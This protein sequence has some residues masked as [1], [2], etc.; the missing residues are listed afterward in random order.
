MV[1]I[2]V[3]STF[4]QVL[5]DLRNLGNSLRGV[6]VIPTVTDA[7]GQPVLYVRRLRKTG[8]LVGYIGGNVPSRP[9][10]SAEMFETAFEYERI[11][12]QAGNQGAKSLV[13]SNVTSNDD[14]RRA[15]TMALCAD[16][17]GV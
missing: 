8:P 7:W 1:L 3:E 10:F 6:H 14:Q 11:G 5:F 2:L 12:R 4:I 13:N 16:D 15:V 9:Q 17:Y